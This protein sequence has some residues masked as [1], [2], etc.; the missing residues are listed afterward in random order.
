MIKKIPSEVL[1][2]IFGYLPARDLRDNVSLTCTKWYYL[3]YSF[4]LSKVCLRVDTP[5]NQCFS[6]FLEGCEKF[7]EFGHDVKTMEVSD[8]Y[9]KRHLYYDDLDKFYKA[10]NLCPNLQVFKISISGMDFW[11][12][13]QNMFMSVVTQLESQIKRLELSFG[14]P[15]YGPPFQ[16]GGNILSFGNGGETLNLADLTSRTTTRLEELIIHN[17]EYFRRKPLVLDQGDTRFGDNYFLTTIKIVC[18]QFGITTACLD[19]ITT[20]HLRALKS[21]DIYLELVESIDGGGYISKLTKS[22]LTDIDFDDI[23]MYCTRTLKTYN[24][25]LRGMH[26]PCLFA[27]ANCKYKED[28]YCDGFYKYDSD[29]SSFDEESSDDD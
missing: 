21:L 17:A 2:Q 20:G 24:I 26:K 7:P 16:S 6:N 28:R 11:R 3:V 1:L 22:D 25:A 8:R 13:I 4:F 10:I 23:E 9:E 29:E 27:I 19:Y 14:Q 15:Q 12:T 18:P 5:F